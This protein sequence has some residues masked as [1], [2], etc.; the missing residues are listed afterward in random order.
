M[1]VAHFL[2]DSEANVRAIDF[3]A[4]RR[5]F[6]GRNRGP[7]EPALLAEIHGEGGAPINGLDPVAGLR[8]RIRIP[9]GGVARLSFATAA[10]PDTDEL[11]ARI[12][13]YLQPM[14]VERATRMAATLAQVRLRDLGVDPEENAALQDINTALMYSCTRPVAERGLVDQRQLWRFGISGDKPIVLVLIHSS[15]G[16]ALVH[17]LL[18]AQPWWSFCGLA[19]DVVILNSEVNSYLMPLQRDILALRDRTLQ[20]AENSFPAGTPAAFSCCASRRSCPP[21]KPRSPAWRA[22]SWWPTAGRWSSRPRHCRPWA[23]RRRQRTGLRCRRHAAG[24]RRHRKATLT[25]PPASS[26]LWS[27]ACTARRAPGST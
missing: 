10:A 12:D 16:M 2:A 27:T 11:A 13:K 20:Q 3:I 25:P 23:A 18:Q 14:H 7:A 21:R 24:P 1:A 15:N 22:S 8:V 17:S 9:A 26:S 6:L 19:A 5:A 4:D